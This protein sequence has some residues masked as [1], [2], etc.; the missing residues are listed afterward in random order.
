MHQDSNFSTSL[1]TLVIFQKNI[2][3]SFLAESGLMWLCTGTSL[4]RQDFSLVVGC[5]RRSAWALYL[6]H[7]L[8]RCGV[9][10]VQLPQGRWDLSSLTRDLTHTPCI[11]KQV[12]NHWTTKEVHVFW[13]ILV[14]LLMDVEKNGLQDCKT[15]LSSGPSEAVLKTAKLILMMQRT[16]STRT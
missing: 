12:L 14:A 7:K 9:Q 5:G 3:L 6:T 13:I 1:P 15:L 16:V 11:G 10:K 4:Q 2:C 8:C